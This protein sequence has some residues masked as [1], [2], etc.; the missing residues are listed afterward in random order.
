MKTVAHC[1]SPY[2][3]VS[4][5]WIHSQIARLRRYR[6]VVLA[7]ETQN[8]EGFP[9][10]ALYDAST[11]PLVQKGINRLLRKLSGKYSFYSGI[12]ER[13]G[14]DL[15]HA[16]FGYQGQFCR[17]AQKATGL[18]MLTSFYGEDGTRYLRYPRW[19]RRYRELFAVGDAFLVEGNAMRQRLQ[20]I[21]C[22]A[23]KLR[24]HHL[25]VDLE[26]IAFRER[27]PV[28]KVRF[29]ICAAFKE[30]KGIPY[31][32]QA[33]GR[34]LEKRAFPCE[35]ILIGDGLERPRVLEG[36]E[37]AGLQQRVQLRGMQPYAQVLEEMQHCDIL[38]QASVTAADG[39]GEGGAPVVLLDAQAAGMPVVAT[40]H[41]DIPEYV[42][43]GHSGLLAPERDVEALSECIRTLVE[44][45]QRWAAIG[46]AGR[47]HVEQNYNVVTQC[48]ALEDI[49]DEFT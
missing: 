15:I 22:P 31:A 42:V 9:V 20:Q 18:P 4:E 32:L 37:R 10:A 30:K 39:D 12:L 7:Q 36:I 3:H 47:R 38:L 11:Y 29:L 6:P 8:V 2:L 13:E 43:D 5:Q 16:H 40:H 17:R 14:A 44:D 1:V 49:Y 23:E 46:R 19:L 41:A 27:Q 28:E 35:V 26:R 33:L 48:A 45:P 24:L 21:G 34:V 25:G